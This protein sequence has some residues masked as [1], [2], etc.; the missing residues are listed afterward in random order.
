MH[1][2]CRCDLG[3]A[4]VDLADYI[5]VPISR[6][7]YDDAIEIVTPGYNVPQG[8]TMSL[9]PDGVSISYS[10]GTVIVGFDSSASKEMPMSS[11]ASKMA[12]D[13][14]RIAE[15]C[16]GDINVISK[17]VDA[18]KAAR[19]NRIV[20]GLK[21]LADLAIIEKPEGSRFVLAYFK[22]N[23]AGALEGVDYAK[24]KYISEDDEDDEYRV[25]VQP[26]DAPVSGEYYTMKRLKECLDER[27]IPYHI[28]YFD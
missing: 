14:H 11:E 4:E 16:N 13:L 6:D 23:E 5:K 15:R 18:I 7:I 20:N 21:G 28:A 22:D 25:Y 12:S 19:K 24:D 10:S 26:G 2:N 9:F 3:S 8:D 1:S 27:E 17:E